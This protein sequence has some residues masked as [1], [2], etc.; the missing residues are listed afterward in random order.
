MA[1]NFSF[2]CNKIQITVFMKKITLLMIF[3]ILLSCEKDCVPY[4]Y[5]RILMTDVSKEYLNVAKRN[6]NFLNQNQEEVVISFEQ[7]DISTKKVDAGDD[8]GCSYFTVEN[9]EQAL[10]FGNYKGRILIGSSTIEIQISNY[11]SLNLNV[12][13][14]NGKEFNDVTESVELNGF[15]FTNVLV[16]PNIN[17]DENSIWD[18]DK[19]IYSKNNG[20]EFI[21]FRDG[22]W[23]KQIL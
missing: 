4:E 18:I 13:E 6:V 11:A 19:I 14:T 16:L 12:K 23:L 9:G 15:T 5:N 2:I 17:T 21:L 22:K 3:F 1:G 8:E 20:I 7:G 10:S